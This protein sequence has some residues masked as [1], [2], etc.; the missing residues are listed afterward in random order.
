MSVKKLFLGLAF[1]LY[2]LLCFGQQPL[3]V[4]WNKTTFL[5]FDAPVKSV[6]RGSVHLLSQVDEA[7]LNLLKLKA[8]KREMEATNLHVLTADGQLHDFT[9]SFS[10]NPLTLTHDLR[11]KNSKETDKVLFASGLSSKDYQKIYQSLS[12]REG[13]KIKQVEGYQMSM[14]L[15]GIYF[16]EDQ[17]FFDLRL[18]NK[19]LIPFELDQ[20]EVLIADK[21]SGKR[22]SSRAVAI[23]PDFNS[24]NIQNPFILEANQSLLLAFPVFTIAEHKILKFTVSERK[25][26]RQLQLKIPGKRL[27]KA[28]DLPISNLLTTTTYGS[29][30]F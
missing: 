17:L 7:G 10:E 9:V 2:G 21:K 19:A 29:G 4:A 22:S 14:A 1:C 18:E 24:A 8:G 23:V 28:A 6:D 25:G 30:E 12:E 16:F 11:S 13:T 27:L 26:D 5:V 3:E 15:R 20:V